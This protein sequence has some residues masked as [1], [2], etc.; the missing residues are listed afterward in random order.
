MQK[1][2]LDIVT[3]NISKKF[4]NIP[5]SFT[6]L[7]SGYGYTSAPKLKNL[8]QFNRLC[9]KPDRKNYVS[10]TSA[11]VPHPTGSGLKVHKTDP[12]TN[13]DS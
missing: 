6:V 8:A 3:R 7:S 11:K 4:P 1:S 12:R 10:D 2:L 13:I 5:N 9:Q